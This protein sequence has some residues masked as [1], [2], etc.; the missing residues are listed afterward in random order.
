MAEP[1]LTVLIEIED[2]MIQG[3][4]CDAP[5]LIEVCVC[6]LDN[7]KAGRPPPQRPNYLVEALS[8]YNH[9]AVGEKHP[10][11]RWFIKNRGRVMRLTFADCEGADPHVSDT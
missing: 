1:R 11:R 8:A 7:I 4:F 3:V 5:D 2:G 10:L 9:P 6:D